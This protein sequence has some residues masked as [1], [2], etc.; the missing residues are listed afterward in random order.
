VESLCDNDSISLIVFDLDVTLI[1]SK[2]DIANSVNEALAQEGFPTLEPKI[3]QGFVGRGLSHLIRDTLGNPSD[4]EA[5]RVAEGFWNHYMKHLLD[6]TGLYSGVKEFLESSTGFARAVVTNKPYAFS[7]KILEGLKIDHH[8]RWLIGGDSLPIQKPSP[9]VF[10]P[11]FA[12]FEERPRGIII[13]DSQIDI[14][15]GQAAGLL[16]CG[17]TYGYR[18]RE[19]IVSAQPDFMIDRFEELKSLPLFR[20]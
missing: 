10:D 3:I 7:K 15:C 20:S 5:K 12:D 19:E 4:E 17:V 9:Q 18:D 16:T 14:D 8:F 2:S 13:G 1:D 6:E 11:I